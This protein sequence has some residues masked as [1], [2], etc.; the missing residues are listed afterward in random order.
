[1]NTRLEILNRIHKVAKDTVKDF[2]LNITLT[3]DMKLTEDLNIDSL[4]KVE[5]WLGIEEEFIIS[6][7]DDDI[8]KLETMKDAVDLVI[9][10]TEKK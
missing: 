3:E 9:K 8:K 2:P 10:Y 1:M 5:I 7:P 4:D 6:I